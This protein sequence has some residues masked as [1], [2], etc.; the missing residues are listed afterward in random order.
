MVYIL[1]KYNPLSFCIFKK[2]SAMQYPIFYVLICLY[3]NVLY[4]QCEDFENPCVIDFNNGEFVY[5]PD[6]ET[7]QSSLQ[8]YLNNYYQTDFQVNIPSDTAFT[9]SGF[10]EIDLEIDY[11][12]I[13][14]IEGLPA[15]LSLDCSNISCTFF[16][17]DFGCF[18]LSGTPT[19]PGEY[20]LNLV[21]SASA[22]W[23]GLPLTQTLDDL[24]QITLIV[25][26]CDDNGLDAFEEYCNQMGEFAVYWMDECQY[27]LC[28][29]ELFDTGPLGECL[30]YNSAIYTN[31][32]CSENCDTVYVEVEVPVTVYVPLLIT[33]TIVETEYV[34][35]IITDTIVET[36]YVDVIIT[37]T[38]VETEYV[39]VIITEY[40]DCE[41]FLPCESGIDEIIEKSKINNKTYNLLGQEIR[42]K[43]GVYIEN[44]E[45][46]YRI[47]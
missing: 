37:D 18:S 20:S 21:V 2:I 24:I 4:G 30:A 22:N 31:E 33:D 36:E 43:E 6:L 28:Q 34:D 9:L 32:N 38:I 12:T 40:V 15:G 5:N 45:V 44:G 3:F 8:A 39:D 46:K 35:V 41:T 13:E 29:C 19:E 11:V 42:I 26:A 17:G 25:S 10:G 23:N 27:Q 7:G 47:N 1:I 14:E 16:G